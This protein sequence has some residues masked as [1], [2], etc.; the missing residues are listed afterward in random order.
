MGRD[1]TR[2]RASR[3]RVV[4]SSPEEAAEAEEAEGIWR[5]KG[6]TRTRSVRSRASSSRFVRARAWRSG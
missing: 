1:G 5:G 6:T 2:A 3:R 4:G